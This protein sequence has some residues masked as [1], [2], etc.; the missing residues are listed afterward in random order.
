MCRA[1]VD[2]QFTKGNRPRVKRKPGNLCPQDKAKMA[3][4]SAL[5]AASSKILCKSKVE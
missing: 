5:Y 3:L 4:A 1:G 2:F